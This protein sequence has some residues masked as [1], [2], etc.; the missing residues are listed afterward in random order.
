MEKDKRFERSKD[1]EQKESCRVGV[2]PRNH[3][4]RKDKHLVTV[5]K[6]IKTAPRRVNGTD[7]PR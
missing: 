3:K 2:V 7:V 1:E 5:E 4:R 6:M